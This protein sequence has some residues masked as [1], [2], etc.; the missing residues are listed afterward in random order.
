MGHGLSSASFP[1]ETRD[2]TLFVEA[3][4]NLTKVLRAET[5]LLTA[6]VLLAGCSSGN[7]MVSGGGGLQGG[8]QGKLYVTDEA[9]NAIL[10]FDNASTA[11]GNVAPGANISGAATQL[12][13]P[14]Y[15]FLD[16]A[17]NRLFVANAGASDILVFDVVSNDAGNVSP[18]RVITSASLATPTDVQLDNA[19]DQLYVAD[20]GQ[21]LVFP[22]AS[23][24]TG[25]N[26]PVRTIQPGFTPAAI[27]LDT[28]NDRLFV[29]DPS[30]NSVDI[31]DGASTLT[32]TVVASR[33]LTGSNTQ[34][35]Q[36]SGLQLDSAG[37]LVVTNFASASLTI[38]ANAATVTSNV[39]PTA[40]ISGGSTTLASP[41]QIAINTAANGGELFVANS[42]G[43]NIPVFSNINTATG[44]QNPAPLRNISGANTLLSGN[45]GARG[46]AIDTTR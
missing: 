19:R 37:R 15:I 17:S 41:N 27:L 5:G 39:A 16:V 44:N 6:L 38:Y 8:P 26:V 28:I 33:K 29:A 46:I 22:S 24:A 23:T 12:N 45:P 18:T 40:V 9:N 2:N 30:T 42:A 32:G 31:F 36:P 20:T 13:H 3:G 11:T 14:Q 7:N 43:A 1:W 34:L 4:M 21:I 25:S 10:R 35:A